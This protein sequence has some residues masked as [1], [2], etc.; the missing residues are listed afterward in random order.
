MHYMVF[1]LPIINC[2]CLFFPASGFSG[3]C[4]FC[5]SD[6]TDMGCCSCFGFL[7]KPRGSQVQFRGSDG[8]LSDDLLIHQDGEDPDRSF[9]NG[10]DTD[11]LY[12][13]D[14][15]PQLSVKRS[16]EIILSRAQS[17]FICRQVPVIETKKAI[18]CEV[19]FL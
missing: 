1:C 13:S 4:S 14:N 8:F 16:E 9:Y 6:L 17:G 11:F 12:E 10:E 18:C 7:R 15:G 2:P 5:M 3:A 19:L